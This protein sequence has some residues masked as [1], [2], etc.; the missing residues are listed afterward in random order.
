[1]DSFMSACDL[2]GWFQLEVGKWGEA[3]SV[4]HILTEPFAVVGRDARAGVV[5]DHHDVSK[6]HAYVQVIDGRAFWVDLRSRTGVLRDGDAKP[7][8]WLDRGTKIRIGP[9]RLGITASED[10]RRGAPPSTVVVPSNPLATSPQQADTMPEVSLELLTRTKGMSCFRLKRT[11]TLVGT[12]LGCRLRLSDPSVSR[13]HFSVL[14]TAMGVWVIDLL[15]QGGVEVNDARVR[16][17]QLD[18]GDILRVGSFAFRL[19]FD[20]PPVRGR[21]RK[22]LLPAT[23][24]GMPPAPPAPATSP[25]GLAQFAPTDG[26]GGLP[27]ARHQELAN[28][29]NL[30]LAAPGNQVAPPQGP[31]ADPFQHLVCMFLQ[32]M[33]TMNEDRMGSWRQELEEIRRLTGE[34]QALQ[35]ELAGIAKDPALSS[36][37]A[38]RPDGNGARPDRLAGLPGAPKQSRAIGRSRERTTGAGPTP[39]ARDEPSPRAH[40]THARHEGHA[41]PAPG[42]RPDGP[43]PGDGSDSELYGIVCRRI[44]SIQDE[45]LGRWQKM[46]NMVMGS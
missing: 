24:A 33:Y 14:R 35:V 34:L 5:L 41:P 40:S 1:M 2:K 12:A 39:H 20:V 30:A 27:R 3:G 36:R 32:M 8:G 6:R 11:L 21:S 31:Q 44:A 45:R 10:D 25:A 17:A 23:P 22:A 38:P 9:Y 29:M 16:S 18:D 4:R 26:A 28:L 46:V 42:P 15:S 13:F 37:E 19:R 43:G 7:F